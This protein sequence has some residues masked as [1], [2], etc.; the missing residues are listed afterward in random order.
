MQSYQTNHPDQPTNAQWASHINA[1]IKTPLKSVPFDQSEDNKL[2]YIESFA[3][4][5][6]N[7]RATDQPFLTYLFNLKPTSI[8]SIPSPTLDLQLWWLLLS[9][10]P[11]IEQ[12]GSVI[13]PTDALI[14]GSDKLAIELRTMIE[15]CSLHALWIHATRFNSNA[16][17]ERCLDAA[18]WHTRELQPDNAINRPWATQVFINLAHQATDKDTSDLAHLHAQTLIHN[19]S[20]SFGA[21]DILSALILYDVAHQLI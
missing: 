17:I 7:R 8:P 13:E 15:L 16:L 1:L 11:S 12:I 14:P 5:F 9:E 4:E 20:I 6:G 19:T 3:D 18:A 2:T 21:P 10:S